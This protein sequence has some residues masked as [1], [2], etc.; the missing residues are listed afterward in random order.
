MAKVPPVKQIPVTC[1]P[2]G[3]LE[4]RALADLT[5]FQGGLKDLDA[6]RYAKL[7]ASILAEGFMAP[8]FVWQDRILDGHQRTIVLEREGWDVEGGVPVVEIEAADE[9]DAARKLLKLTSS[10]GKPQP[11]GVFDFMVEHDLDLG[12]FADVDLPD[13]D[14]DALAVLFGDDDSEPPTDDALEPPVQPVTRLGDLWHMGSSRIICGDCGQPGAVWE[15]LKQGTHVLADPPY[16]IGFNYAGIDD[17]MADDEYAAFCAAWF[18]GLCGPLLGR[19]GGVIVSPGP[20]NA[21]RYPEPR[22]RGVWIKR[23]AT[24]GASVFHLRLA[25]PLLFYGTFESKRNTDV[26]DYSTGFGGELVQARKETGTL[27]EHPPVKSWPLWT[28]LCGMLSQGIVVDPFAGN[29]TTLLVATKAGRTCYTSDI[30][31]AYVDLTVIRWQEHTNQQAI[32]DGD[33]RTFAEVKAERLS[34]ED[35]PQAAG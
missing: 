23:N 16:N 17:D 32:L 26:F 21:S 6:A 10:Y 24:A 8:V 1:D 14:E 5:P 31:P 29:G 3:H 12:D 20:K 2:H 18:D 19:G 25:E 11:E 15:L 13:F 22:D 35:V 30:E 28:E 33:G 9:S 34:G 7:K 4:R 27:T